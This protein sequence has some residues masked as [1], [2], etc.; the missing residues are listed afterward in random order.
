MNVIVRYLQLKFQIKREKLEYEVQRRR[1]NETGRIKKDKGNSDTRNLAFPN[2]NA[3]AILLLAGSLGTRARKVSFRVSSPF[4]PLWKD[5]GS[6]HPLIFVIKTAEFAVNVCLLFFLFFFIYRRWQTIARI[7]FCFVQTCVSST[8]RSLKVITT[9][10]LQKYSLKITWCFFF[11][12]MSSSES[13]CTS[14]Y[15]VRSIGMIIRAI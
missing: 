10:C 15:I 6:I 9:H 14:I 3:L 11:Y 1:K 2:V 8:C 4:T 12:W 13:A 5:R 7:L